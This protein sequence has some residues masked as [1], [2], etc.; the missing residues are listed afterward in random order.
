MGRPSLITV[1]IPA[2]PDTGIAVTGTAVTLGLRSAA[3]GNAATS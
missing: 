3:P 2:G 1:D